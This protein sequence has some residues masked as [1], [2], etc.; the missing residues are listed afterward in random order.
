MSGSSTCGGNLKSCHQIGVTA[1]SSLV[2]LAAV[3]VGAR[4]IGYEARTILHDFRTTLMLG[5]D[6]VMYQTA[7]DVMDGA[8]RVHRTVDDMN[9]GITRLFNYANLLMLIRRRRARQ[10]LTTGTADHEVETTGSNI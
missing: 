3:I 9:N 2:I 8:N 6:I 7:T 1:L 10:G 5:R 4:V